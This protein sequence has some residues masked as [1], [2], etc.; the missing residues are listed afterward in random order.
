MQL[1]LHWVPEPIDQPSGT[2]IVLSAWIWDTKLNDHH[3]SSSTATHPFC[4]KHKDFPTP[5]RY[6]CNEEDFSPTTNPISRCTTKA[7]NRS[8]EDSTAGC[9]VNG[10]HEVPE[11]KFSSKNGM[12]H[13][14]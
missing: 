11:D 9:S 3:D 8:A 5:K 2:G 12:V 4:V 7:G 6:H 10:G 13:M 14:L 1:W